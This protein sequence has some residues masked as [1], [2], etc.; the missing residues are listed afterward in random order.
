LHIKTAT[1]VVFAFRIAIDPEGMV[2]RGS[3]KF[4]TPSLPAN[5]DI[6]QKDCNEPSRI[7]WGTYTFDENSSKENVSVK[8]QTQA[9]Y[10]KEKRL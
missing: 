7:S 10:S 9:S 6:S 4:L 5:E 1:V 2:E 3:C 8:C